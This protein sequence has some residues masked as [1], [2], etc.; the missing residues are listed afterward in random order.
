[1]TV[2]PSCSS[3]AVTAVAQVPAP[4]T[5]AVLPI[6][7]PD[8]GA[9]MVMV[10]EENAS[11]VTTQQYNNSHRSISTPHR[12]AARMYGFLSAL[13]NKKLSVCHL[14]ARSARRK[15]SLSLCA[16]R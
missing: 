10:T 5:S 6:K 7:G 12:A 8:R 3:L 16:S 11:D 14:S 9:A 4:S 15:G 2:A 1:M 13:L